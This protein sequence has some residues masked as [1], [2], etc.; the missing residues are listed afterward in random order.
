MESIKPYNTLFLDRDGVI[1]VHRPDDYVKS[2]DAFVFID[3]VPEAIALLAPLFKYILIVTN[4]RGVGKGLMSRQDLEDIHHFMQQQIVSAGGRIDR[5]YVATETDPAHRNRKPHTGMIVQ[6]QKDFPDID[7]AS[8]W[9]VGD[10]ISDMQLANNAGI[11]AVLL[12]DKYM[13]EEISNLRIHASYPDLYTFAQRILLN[14]L[15]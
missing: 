6:A 2:V 12:G 1:N 8:S 10:S 5:I 11:P 9:V 13:P 3:R 15:V 14:P 7:L 4:Q